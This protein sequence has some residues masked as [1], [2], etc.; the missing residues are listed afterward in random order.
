MKTKPILLVLIEVAAGLALCT[1]MFAAQ[2]APSA[3][4]TA[5]L[6]AEAWAFPVPPSPPKLNAAKID[7]HKVFHLAGSNRTY[8]NGQISLSN[9]PD[10]FPQDHPLMPQ[11]VA[12]GRKPAWAC[13]FC[14]LPNGEGEP[15]SASLMGLPKAYILEQLVS[16]RDGERGASLPRNTQDMANE[17]HGLTESD[18]QLAAEYFSQLKFIPHVH[19]VETSTVPATGWKDWVLVPN[20]SSAPQPIG[21]R[22]IEIP[23]N[24]HD[25]EYRSDRV[26]YVAYAPL[27][28]IARGAVIAAKGDG[29][30]AACE[31][32]HGTELEGANLPDIG[33]APPL[34]GRSPTY[35]VRELI[36]FCTGKRSD[37]AAAPMRAEASQLTI[38][39]MI[40]V[41]AYAASRKP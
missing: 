41:A 21:E 9:P 37:P 3:S 12:H 36:L 26:S 19:V 34:A 23:G 28:S 38:P 15:A 1:T 20:K 25:Y 31:S 32:C 39:Q 10:W 33:I 35:I 30:A 11:I 4:S 27:G 2:P 18:M 17:A 8:T 13:G 5:I 14:H 40:D 29:S 7:P 16:F 24:V 22:I 6:A